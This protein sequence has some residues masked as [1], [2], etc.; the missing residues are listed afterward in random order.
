ML[1]TSDAAKDVED[2]VKLRCKAASME[3]AV[4]AKA[5]HAWDRDWGVLSQ[6]CSA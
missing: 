3:S 4:R 5:V 1:A 2:H 6:L